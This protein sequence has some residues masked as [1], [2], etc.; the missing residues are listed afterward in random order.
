MKKKDIAVNGS[1]TLQV[2]ELWDK[3]PVFRDN[4]K[5]VPTIHLPFDKSLITKALNDSD[6]TVQNKTKNG[7][8]FYS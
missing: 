8:W 6:L 1:I 7:L 2:H 4:M 5:K 3:L